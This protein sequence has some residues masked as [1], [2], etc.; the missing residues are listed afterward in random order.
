MLLFLLLLLTLL[1][2][3]YSGSEAAIFSQDAGRLA[4]MRSDEFSPRLRKTVIGWLRRPERIITG[5]LLG[6]LIV[7]IGMTNIWET[8]IVG[9][10]GEFTHRHIVLPVVIT[11]YVLTFGEVIPKI[12]ALVFKDTWVKALQLPLRGWFR[13]SARF[14]S[15]F[16]R[17]TARL[18]KPLKP[19]SSTLTEAELVEAV[20]FAEDH[21]LLKSEEMRMLSRSIAFY[22]NTVYAAMIPRSQILLLPEGTSLSAARKAFL[23]S[24]HNFAA[25]Y[26]RNSTEIEGVIYLR[27]VVQLQLARKKNLENKVHP[28]EFLPA[29]LSLSAALSSLMNN[30]RDIAAVVDEAGAFIGMVTLRGIINHILGASFSPV[31]QDTYLEQLDNRR[32][33]VAAQMPLDRFNEIFRTNLTAELSETIG[34]Y[35]L[36]HLDGFPHGDEEIPIGNL[37]FRN[38][39]LEE[40]RIRSFVLVVKRNG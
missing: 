39:D 25:I 31:P 15:P 2:G 5:L 34:G 30:R 19:V 16:D 9:E 21:G 23:A 27:G 37:T 40:H 7:N 1:S 33:R 10:F 17:L 20:R 35:L 28:V 38:F 24:A 22:H 12:I 36:E 26:R 32:Y 18:V 29:S 8:W 3:F 14:T 6:N 13:F 4:R 11:L